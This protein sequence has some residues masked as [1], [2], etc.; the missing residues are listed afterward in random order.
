[1][2][3][4]FWV[5][6]LVALLAMSGVLA[7]ESPLPG[8][9]IYQLD[10]ALTDQDG[11]SQKLAAR[12][13]TPQLVTM[14]Y[15]SCTMVC[16]IIIDTLKM[17]RKAV[18]DPPRQRLGVLAVSF[19]PEHDTVGVLRDYADAQKIDLGV[20]TLARAEAPAVRQLAAVLGLQYRQLPDKNF[21]HSS[22]LVLLD[23]EGRII[24]RTSLIGRIDPE[25]V[26]IVRKT[27]AGP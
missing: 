4:N 12:R 18:G 25:F 8:A 24:A 13:G 11:D 15:T 22:Q 20:F 3:R 14:F 26:A 17:T 5:A 7:T 9:S 27:V 19:D 23:R 21:N 10:I 6:V 1:M 2:L 16:P